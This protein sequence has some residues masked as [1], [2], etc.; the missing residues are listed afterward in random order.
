MSAADIPTIPRPTDDVVAEAE[1]VADAKA[2]L[3]EL[4]AR[5]KQLKETIDAGE[6]RLQQSV[7][8]IRPASP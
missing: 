2:L 1:R 6:T 5:T 7:A 3:R 8:A 4:Q